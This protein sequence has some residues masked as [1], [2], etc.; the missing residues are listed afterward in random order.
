MKKILVTGGTGYIGSHTVVALLEQGLTPVI[1][2]NLH[3]SSAAV[4]QRI[5]QITGTTPELVKGD[6][7]DGALLTQLFS[8]H[9]FDAVIHF[10]GLKA[11]G[12]SVAQPLRY[13]QNNVAGSLQLF[14][15]MAQHQ[16]QRIV[17]S[18]SATVYGDPASVPIR[19]DFALHAT[20]PYGQSKLM[21]ENI[22]RDLSIADA[23][24]QVSILRYFN[25]IAAHP[26]GLIGE[27]PNGVPNNLMPYIAQVGIGKLKQLSIWG[28]DYATNDGTGVRDYIH[29]VDLA[30]AHLKALQALNQTHACQAYN[31][32]TGRG[33]SVLEMVAAFE[34]AS[35]KTIPYAIKPRRAGDI[36]TCY[37]DPSYSKKQLDWQAKYD[38]DKMMQDHW[39][40][41]LNNPNGY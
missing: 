35:N 32:G 40:W 7:R 38:L 26:S 17:F 10:A 6:I 5:E 36:A 34:R 31:I 28:N 24:W 1:L 30:N 8:Q 18:S 25:P 12:E 14:T 3:N 29:V 27:H 21:V 37:A 33:Y 9:Q 41:Q 11:V 13:Y 16:C 20:N 19:E 39:R 2:D 22:L 4:V 23:A 15:T